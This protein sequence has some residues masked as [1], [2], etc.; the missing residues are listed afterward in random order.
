MS[1]SQPE[2]KALVLAATTGSLDPRQMAEPQR[3]KLEA[4][5]KASAEARS[6]LLTRN[7]LPAT[8]ARTASRSMPC[9][10]PLICV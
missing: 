10:R 1:A 7:I 6:D 3:S 2:V 4:W 8:G 5:S 9:V